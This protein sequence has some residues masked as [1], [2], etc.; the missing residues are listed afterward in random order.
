M[1]ILLVGLRRVGYM[2]EVIS[3]GVAPVLVGDDVDDI[4]VVDARSLHIFFVSGHSARWVCA[5]FDVS[6]RAF[7]AR[8]RLY[9][10]A[11]FFPAC[12]ARRAW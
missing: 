3:D 10:E 7:E 9:D 4:I 11:V 1:S 2:D 12:L 6:T 8:S 5:L